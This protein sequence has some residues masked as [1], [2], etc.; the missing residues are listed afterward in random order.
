M[1]ALVV[2]VSH[3]SSVPEEVQL[4]VLTF[5]TASAEDKAKTRASWDTL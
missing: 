3:M 4:K 1:S 5:A 2:G